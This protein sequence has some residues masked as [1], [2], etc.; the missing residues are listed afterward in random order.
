MKLY[1]ERYSFV[2]GDCFK[3]IHVWD[4]HEAGAWL[5]DAQ[6]FRG[7]KDSVEDLQCSPA[8]PDVCR[9]IA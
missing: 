9:W 6:P 2:S 3:D 4:M 5:I 7:H 1:I 8:E